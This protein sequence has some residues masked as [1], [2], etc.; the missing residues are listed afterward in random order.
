MQGD[1]RIERRVLRRHTTRS[2]RSVALA[3]AIAAVSTLA[4]T[5]GGGP[6]TA[7]APDDDVAEWF[8]EVDPAMVV[9]KSSDCM[10]GAT[11]TTFYRGDRIVMRPTTAM[12]DVAVRDAV[13]AALNGIYGT[14]TGKDWATT[15]ERIEFPQPGG[16]VI[17]PVLS[18]SLAAAL[19]WRAA[20]GGRVGSRASPRTHQHPVVA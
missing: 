12:S 1:L 11:D 8:G 19:R 17:R 6:V 15:V 10:D 4:A 14:P 20:R 3:T 2:R 18:V 9:D 5:A 16:P 7:V 13:D